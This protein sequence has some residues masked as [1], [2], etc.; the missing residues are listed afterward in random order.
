MWG[1]ITREECEWVNWL[2]K[3]NHLKVGKHLSWRVGEKLFVIIRTLRSSHDWRVFNKLG[4]TETKINWIFRKYKMGILSTTLFTSWK[5]QAQ[6]EGRQLLS[7]QGLDFLYLWWESISWDRKPWIRRS[8][9]GTVWC[10][11]KLIK[12]IFIQRFYFKSK[13]FCW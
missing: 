10:C 4:I 9:I 2:V 3:I 7:Y 5:E 12:K 8:C 6:N 13:K 1:P 11:K